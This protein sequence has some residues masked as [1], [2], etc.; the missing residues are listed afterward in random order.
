MTISS[1]GG[2]ERMRS[3]SELSFR[4]QLKKKAEKRQTGNE[5]FNL[6]AAD[7]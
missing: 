6:S 1:F 3:V 5:F 7:E 4:E 2:E